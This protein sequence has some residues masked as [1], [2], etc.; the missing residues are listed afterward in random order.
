MEVMHIF[1]NTNKHK[2]SDVGWAYIYP[3]PVGAVKLA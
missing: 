3:L 2:I 1:D